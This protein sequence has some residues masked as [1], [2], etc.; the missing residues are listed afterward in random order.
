MKWKHSPIAFFII[1]IGSIKKLKSS[2]TKEKSSKERTKAKVKLKN[3]ILKLKKNRQKVAKTKTDD[4]QVKLTSEE[5]KLFKK[6]V[7]TYE[8]QLA[9]VQSRKESDNYLNARHKC[10]KC[11]R[12]FLD[13]DAY[14][15]HMVK[16][17]NVSAIPSY[18]IEPKLRP[19]TWT[20]N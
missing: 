3:G 17:T 13:V 1:I 11:Y 18:K 2:K 12:G 10:T 4:S 9:E 8:E 14:N 20:I 16:H 5:K 19:R 6:T 15:L 7:L